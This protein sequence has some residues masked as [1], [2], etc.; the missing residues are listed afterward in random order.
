MLPHAFVHRAH[1]YTNVP[2]VCKD[3]LTHTHPRTCMHMLKCIRTPCVQIVV[4]THTRDKHT[5]MHTREYISLNMH[6]YTHTRVHAHR[7]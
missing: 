6:T 7:V 1:G 5:D 4:L 3:M 2:R